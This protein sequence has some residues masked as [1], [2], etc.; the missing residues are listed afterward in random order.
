MKNFLIDATS[1]KGFY[2]LLLVIL[3]AGAMGCMA[4]PG[5]V[6]GHDILFHLARLEGLAQGIS[7]GYPVYINSS[8]LEGYGY[9]TGLFY[10]DIFLIFPAL[11][12]NVGLSTIAAYKIFIV[13]WAV[14]N[15]LCMYFAARRISGNRHAAFL[16]GALYAFSS[17]MATDIFTRAALGEFLAFPF[18]T[19]A[20]WGGYELIYGNPKRIAPF[21]FGLSGLVLTHNISLLIAMVIFPI[22]F[23][24]N[25]VRLIKR[26]IRIFYAACGGV[27]ALMISSFYWIP[28]LQ[29]L[30]AQKM[31]MM[32]KTLESPIA[33]RAV[34]F[35][36]LFFEIPYMKTEFW[37]PPGIG[38]IFVILLFLR[39]AFRSKYRRLD[40]VRDSMLILGFSCI[41]CSTNFLPWEGAFKSFGAIQFPWRL[42]L[43]A[44][45]FLS[46]G[47]AITVM[48]WSRGNS[49]RWIRWTL[50]VLVMCAFSWCLNVGY[51]YAAKI[52]E[53]NMITSFEPA[54]AGK[55]AASGLHYLPAKTKL[56]YI[57]ERGDKVSVT[58]EVPYTFTR[59]G[60]KGIL[61]LDIPE[62]TGDVNVEMPFVWYVGYLAEINDSGR[63]YATSPSENGLVSFTV[64]ESDSKAKLALD[65]NGTFEQ[66]ASRWFSIIVF[67]A[68]TGV[69]SL[70]F[71]RRKR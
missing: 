18:F 59:D 13:L 51:I 54:M 63:A 4:Y 62:G 41:V 9:A 65:Y 2:P 23:L 52:S 71:V 16:A 27:I 39:F 37:H 31:Q 67:A 56:A 40:S 3:T 60:K 25:I 57:Y 20:V 43:A 69:I 12:R 53:K 5:I 34:P 46:I 61:T 11:L 49:A 44:T 66:K 14:F 38:L 28:M 19:L 68:F 32:E 29:Q 22:W 36:R 26:P 64:R 17:Y 24:C 10:P 35:T 58:P 6:M 15:A 70:R 45:V 30:F 55:L 1:R 42:Y 7:D 21:V 33:L 50:I 47:S 8:A 48:S